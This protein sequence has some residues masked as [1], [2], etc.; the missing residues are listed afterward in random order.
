MKWRPQLTSLAE[1][2]GETIRQIITLC[3]EASQE[4][5]SDASMTARSALQNP[6]ID[7]ETRQR[8]ALLGPLLLR[9]RY[10]VPGRIIVRS[11]RDNWDLSSRLVVIPMPSYHRLIDYGSMDLRVDNYVVKVMRCCTRGVRSEEHVF[12]SPFG[13]A[14]TEKMLMRYFNELWKNHAL[15]PTR[16]I[17]REAMAYYR[18]SLLSEISDRVPSQEYAS[19]MRLLAQASMPSY[20]PLEN[21]IGT[22]IH[23]ARYYDL[24]RLS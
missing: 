2:A 4:V 23:L 11:T 9:A 1:H 24:S 19:Y 18:W 3:Q 7:P 15:Y 16:D 10:A 8:A 6:E 22:H 12:V 13:T 5:F 20:L 14:F 21:P 17:M